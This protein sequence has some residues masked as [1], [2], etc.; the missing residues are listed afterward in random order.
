[1][2]RE[3][4]KSRFSP[5]DFKEFRHRLKKETA[6]L[7]KWFQREHFSRSRRSIGLELETWLVDKKF[8]PAP[9]N[10][11]FLA[12]MNHPMVVAEL[13][14][15]NTEINTSPQHLSGKC[16][17]KIHQE[18]KKTWAKVQKCA[19]SLGLK[20][21]MIG[22]LP[23]LKSS[24]LSMKHMSDMDR[25]RALNEQ[26]MYLRQNRDLK[27][28][29][30]GR[31]HLE[32]IEKSVMLEA[33]STSLQ[34]HLQVEPTA[35]RRHFNAAMI[36][37]APM[38]AVASNSPFL[39]GKDLWNETRIPL[40]EQ[41]VN[42]PGFQSRS[43]KIVRRVTFGGGYVKKSMGEFYQENLNKYPVLLPVVY[44]E[45]DEW[46]SH[47]RLH[48][49]TI[50]RWNR[51]II[52]L[53]Q[54]GSLSLRIEHRVASSGPTPVDVVANIAFS[55][56][57]IR[58]LAKK[59]KPPEKELLFDTA[60]NNFYQAAQHGLEAKITWMGKKDVPLKILILETL[61]PQAEKGLRNLGV[62]S[63]D[64]RYYLGEIMTKRVESGRTGSQWQRDYVACHGKNFQKLI[65]CYYENQERDKPVHS[66]KI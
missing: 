54:K 15:F 34:I 11:R 38:V 57:L 14:R 35:T 2:G 28:N 44:D 31:D 19:N 56:G 32:L 62:S 3:I 66:W 63:H 24:A 36:V 23:T 40:F 47:L 61:L 1:M 6:I 49:G 52:G 43:G 58:N 22:T 8:N 7:Q 17:T 20:M 46:L 26:I 18:F 13:S 12:K 53:S 45:E 64:V 16:F 42:L 50:W 27:I 4:T 29:I 60:R 30:K 33:A 10:Q 65:K 5:L 55:V 9:E 37:S 48:N 51:P 59:R 41:A 21:L 25:Y 39:F